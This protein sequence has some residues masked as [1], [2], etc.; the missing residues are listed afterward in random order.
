MGA[1][2][3]ATAFGVAEIMGS[4]PTFFPCFPSSRARTLVAVTIGTSV[5]AG[6]KLGARP[7]AQRVVG[8]AGGAAEGP[9]DGALATRASIACRTSGICRR[10]GARSWAGWR[11]SDHLP[12]R[13]RDLD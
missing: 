6:W 12:L 10:L 13:R 4:V 7:W 5:P 8:S 1:G 2:L 9:G 11:R 3:Q